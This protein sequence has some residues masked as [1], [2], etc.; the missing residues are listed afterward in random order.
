MVSSG[1]NGEEVGKKL[2]WRNKSH[3][4]SS[5]TKGTSSGK[6]VKAKRRHLGGIRVIT[7]KRKHKI[8]ME[9][10]PSSS[11]DQLR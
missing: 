4:G 3:W 9:H 10:I 2:P 6:E 5:L 1:K 7:V 11:S 8:Q